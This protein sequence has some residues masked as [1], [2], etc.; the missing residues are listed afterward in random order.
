MAAPETGTT[1][2]EEA[3]GTYGGGGGREQNNSFLVTFH[4]RSTANGVKTA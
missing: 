1:E 3:G 4:F 2:D